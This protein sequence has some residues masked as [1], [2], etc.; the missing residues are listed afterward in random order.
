MRYAIINGARVTNVVEADSALEE[1]WIQSDTAGIGDSYVDG[2]F[3]RT[4]P[5][6]DVEMTKN[7]A[8]LVRAMRNQYLADTD[9]RF[10]SDMNPSQE[11]KDY[12]QA[13]RDV[14][15]QSG[16]PWTVQ[17]PDQP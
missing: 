16:F 1:N 12:C 2:Q 15:T 13:L 3:V 11:W 9:W 8:K 5:K 14:P 7:K 17:W 6:E 4:D 10:R